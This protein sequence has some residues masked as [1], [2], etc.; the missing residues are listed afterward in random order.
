VVFQLAGAVVQ[1]PLTLIQRGASI[2]AEQ[3]NEMN[4]IIALL[5]APVYAYYAVK[6]LRIERPTP[7]KT[8]ITIGL[9]IVIFV[10]FMIITGTVFSHL[11]PSNWSPLAKRIVVPKSKA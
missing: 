9:F 3:I 4:D 8:A 1:L 10:G 7:R 11:P 2:T 6:K 5:S